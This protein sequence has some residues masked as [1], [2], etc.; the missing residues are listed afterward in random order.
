M[1]ACQ[2]APLTPAPTLSVLQCQPISRCT[3]PAMA[4]RTNGELRDAFEATKGAWGLCAAKVDM[5][6]DCQV[7]AQAKID[8]EMGQATHE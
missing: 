1:S 4:P 2:Q 7:K 3:L 5:V 8:A 6:V